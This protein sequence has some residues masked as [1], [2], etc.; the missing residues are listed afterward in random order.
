MVEVGP[1]AVMH[2]LTRLYIPTWLIERTGLSPLGADQVERDRVALEAHRARWEERRALVE[3]LYERQTDRELDEPQ[4]HFDEALAG[5]QF[6]SAA[7]LEQ[8][9]FDG[10]R[11]NI[12]ALDPAEEDSAAGRAQIYAYAV[13]EHI[14]EM[15]RDV[16]L[17][18]NRYVEVIRECKH[19]MAALSD[20]TTLEPQVREAIMLVLVRARHA[21]NNARRQSPHSMEAA[22]ARRGQELRALRAL[23]RVRQHT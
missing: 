8:R 12:I 10:R 23:E 22:A 5:C 17:G 21:A 11:Y 4:T 1:L 9:D 16:S 2:E 6:E 19:W 3:V 7:Q 15:M 13:I 18:A 20:D 14:E